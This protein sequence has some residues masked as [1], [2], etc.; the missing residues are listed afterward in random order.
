VEIKK[1]C[2]PKLFFREIFFNLHLLQKLSTYLESARRVDTFW[3]KVRE[4]I[5]DKL[6]KFENYFLFADFFIYSTSIWSVTS[7]D[8]TWYHVP[9]R[10]ITWRPM[11]PRDC[12]S[13][14]IMDHHGPSRAVT[15][16]H[17]ISRDITRHHVISRK[18][19]KIKFFCYFFSFFV[20][21]WVIVF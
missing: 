5:Q 15:N 17:V 20:F 7:R 16:R 3:K 18:P 2:F 8:I 19:K 12:P 11:T 9:S 6:K 1:I 4:S 10:E 14:T 13:R 21:L